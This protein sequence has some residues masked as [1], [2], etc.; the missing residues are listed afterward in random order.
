MTL[1][2]DLDVQYKTAFV[3]SL[4]VREAMATEMRGYF[5]GYVKP[6]NNKEN[7]VDRRLLRNQNGKRQCVVVVRQRDGHTLPAAFPSESAA[8][9]FIRNHVTEGTEIMAEEANSWNALHSRCVWRRT[10]MNGQTRNRALDLT[11]IS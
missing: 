5:G 8:M 11:Q 2:R 6:A 10:M 4:K 9:A 3:L 7:R 1:S